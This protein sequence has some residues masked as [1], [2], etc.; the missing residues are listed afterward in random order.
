LDGGVAVATGETENTEET[1]GEQAPAEA[2]GETAVPASE[3]ETG[4][5]PAVQ[6]ADNTPVEE[7]AEDKQS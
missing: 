3:A 2:G 7:S 1:A 5:F 4:E 6:E